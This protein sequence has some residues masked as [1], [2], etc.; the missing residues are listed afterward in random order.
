MK[1]CVRLSVCIFLAACQPSVTATLPPPHVVVETMTPSPTQTL[2]PTVTPTTAELI[3][4]FT[5]DGL[6]HHKYQSGKIHIR[7]TLD[8]KN[9]FYNSYLIDYPSDGLRITGIMQIPVGEGP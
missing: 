5:L 3:Y 9:Q 2:T 6:R 8:D 1:Q 4:S 7:S